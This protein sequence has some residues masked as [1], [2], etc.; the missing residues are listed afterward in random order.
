[1]YLPLYN[2]SSHQQVHWEFFFSLFSLTCSILLTCP[3]H[4]LLL[5]YLMLLVKPS[6]SNRTSF[7]LISPLFSANTVVTL[8]REI[9]GKCKLQNT[10]Y[11]ITICTA[12]SPSWEAD[13][14]WPSKENPR[15]L[16]NPEFY[17]RFRKSPQQDIMKWY[18]MRWYISYIWNILWRTCFTVLPKFIY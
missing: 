3:L 6:S 1:M 9:R 15:I 18:I 17:Y 13:N 8:W 11:S 7:S 16:W 14:F 2:Y 5:G 4:L 12:H 10:F